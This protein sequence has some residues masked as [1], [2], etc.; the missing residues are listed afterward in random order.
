MTKWNTYQLIKSYS[1]SKYPLV[2][3]C[4]E[5][6]SASG[7]VEPV[8][9]TIDLGDLLCSKSHRSFLYKQPFWFLSNLLFLSHENTMPSYF[10]L[11]IWI[12]QTLG[13]ITYIEKATE[14]LFTLE[15]ATQLSLGVTKGNDLTFLSFSIN[16]G[17]LLLQ[18]NTA[19]FPSQG[20]HSHDYPL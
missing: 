5:C 16:T 6:S 20:I 17:M 4:T 2:L 9:P 13:N 3:L 10:F 15:M 19:I 14:H 18:F 11:T 1:C 12:K 7:N 8:C